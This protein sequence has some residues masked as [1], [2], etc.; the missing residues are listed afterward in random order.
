WIDDLTEEIKA[1][2]HLQVKVTEL[3]KENQVV[4]VSAKATKQNPW[5]DCTKRYFEFSE[6]VGTVSGVQEYGVF[7]NLEPNVDALVSHM[8][9]E[10]IQKGDKVLLRVTK[11][12]VKE[13]QIRGRI[14][15]KI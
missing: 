5:P 8:K 11:I 7:V 10:D 12:D 4:K 13:E 1:G 6:Y 9:F 15:K 2:D 14:V 3:D